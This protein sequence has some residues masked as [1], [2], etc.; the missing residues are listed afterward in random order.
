[1]IMCSHGPDVSQPHFYDQQKCY[2][3]EA[4]SKPP[5]VL[6]TPYTSESRI[7]KR[8][9]LYRACTCVFLDSP[10]TDCLVVVLQH[11]YSG[12]SSG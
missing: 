11:S 12:W 4:A 2:L 3:A 10:A 9:A 1:M 5:P 6:P 7:G 8:L